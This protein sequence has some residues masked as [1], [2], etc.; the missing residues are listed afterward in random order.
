MLDVPMSVHLATRPSRGF[1]AQVKRALAWPARVIEARRTLAT[2]AA[3]S[4]HELRD[5]GLIRQDIADLTALAADEDPTARLAR[6]RAGRAWQ[7]HN[8]RDQAA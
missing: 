4:D 2:L 3:L 6:A 1:V 8:G 5:I 7:S